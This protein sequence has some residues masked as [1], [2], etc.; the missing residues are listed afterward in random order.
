MKRALSFSLLTAGAICFGAWNAAAAPIAAPPAPAEANSTA[1]RVQ[2]HR[3]YRE[4]RYHRHHRHYSGPRRYYGPR[5]YGY[6]PYY[7]DYYYGGPSV[8]VG[9]PFFNLYVGPRHRYYDY[10]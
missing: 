6:G 3:H 2:K 1:E 10:W 4:R 8:S 9:V 5:Y 7:R